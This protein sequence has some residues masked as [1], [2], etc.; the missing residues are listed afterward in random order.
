MQ[1]DWKKLEIHTD[2]APDLGKNSNLKF[3]KFRGIDNWD[4]AKLSQSLT[5]VSKSLRHLVLRGYTSRSQS[6]LYLPALPNLS[7]IVVRSEG[8]FHFQFSDLSG[9]AMKKLKTVTFLVYEEYGFQNSRDNWSNPTVTRLRLT[10]LPAPDE[11]ERYKN[12]FPNLE[13]FEIVA[14]SGLSACDPIQSAKIFFDRVVLLISILNLKRISI[15]FFYSIGCKD[16]FK[17]LDDNKASLFGKGMVN[18]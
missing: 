10:G 9:Q 17:T 2:W 7:K 14:I 3:F 13:D 1:E 18:R 8:S 11:T 16:F 15:K 4:N 12:F 5:Q 6:Q